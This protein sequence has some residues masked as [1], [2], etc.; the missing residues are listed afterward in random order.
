MLGEGAGISAVGEFGEGFFAGL[1]PQ[2]P[3]GGQALG[4]GGAGA[5]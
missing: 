5:E 2:E 3:V 1:Q 4:P